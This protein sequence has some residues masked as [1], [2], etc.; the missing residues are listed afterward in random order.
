[1]KDLI[2]KVISRIVQNDFCWTLLDRTLLRVTRYADLVNKRS[3]EPEIVLEAIQAVCPDLVVKHGTFK[4][5]RYPQMQSIGSTIF[6]KLIGSYEREIQPLIESICKA[7]YTEFVDIGCAEGYY[8]VGLAM[9]VPAARVYA[10]DTD[11]EAIHLCNEMARLN[12]VEQRVFTG[13]FCDSETLTSIP[14]KKKGLIICD[15]E[16]YEKE[17][18]SKETVD[19]LTNCD[20]L[21]EIHDII[22]I[23]ISCF[24]RRIF[25][26]SH[27]IEVVESVDD[28]RK[29]HTY[30]YKEI[31]DY[32][33]E[34]RRI[35]LA[36]NRASIMEWFY[37]TRRK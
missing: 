34:T 21:I 35:L 22:D 4:G 26:H 6:P 33:L 24:I 3:K 14:I 17:L 12:G 13:S 11:E 20:F 23:S 2:K 25:E 1:M 31:E 7:D 9:H 15:C 28:I 16:G 32:D 37:I 30:Y 18:F 19:A 8:A 10:Y 29:A 36:E 5:M 27:Q